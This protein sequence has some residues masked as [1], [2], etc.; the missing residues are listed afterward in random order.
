[1]WRL[2]PVER[3]KLMPDSPGPEAPETLIAAFFAARGRRVD[4]AVNQMQAR[5]AP[6]EMAA[7]A[8]L[9]AESNHPR[10]AEFLDMRFLTDLP[11]EDALQPFHRQSISENVSFYSD[12]AAPADK[13]LLICFAGLGGRLGVPTPNFLQHL[14]ARR[15]DVLLLRD[16]QK[17]R[18]RFGVDDLA[19]HFFGLIEVIR[20]RFRPQTYRRVV[21]Y[22]NSMG[23][24]AALR[25]GLFL[26]AER[27]IAVG[28]RDSNDPVML[29][30]GRHPGPAFD[31]ICDCL[32]ERPLAGLIVYPGGCEAD[33]DG[34]RKLRA[35]GAGRIVVV[36]RLELHNVAAHFW[37]RGELGGYLAHLID[38]PLPGPR[39]DPGPDAILRRR[40]F[41]P[42]L[43]RI[44]A[45]ERTD[46]AGARH[47]D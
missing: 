33:A 44:M 39:H 11:G 2:W 27:A 41:L 46:G 25:A 24:T 14:D 9:L 37:N 4:V 18:F 20:E 16:P 42:S 30:L 29:L 26:A 31:P 22:G 32:S 45:L 10:R 17:S 43:K 13:T 38:A 35:R 34:A 12:G 15:F 21:T 23:G 36:P 6:R 40:F 3:Q 47:S 5:F 19:A 7:F 1:M 8:R 28:A